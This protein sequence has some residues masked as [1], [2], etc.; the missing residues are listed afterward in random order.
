MPT[1]RAFQLNDCDVYAGEDLEDAI[2]AAIRETGN[3]REEVFE[4]CEDCELVEDLKL[5]MKT[6]CDHCGS[7]YKTTI[8]EYLAKME[9]PGILC[10]TEC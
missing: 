4:G 5:P 9:K 3:T 7:T 2:A 6:E 8:G 1:L 10:S